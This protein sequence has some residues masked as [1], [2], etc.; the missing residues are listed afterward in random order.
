MQN[1][2][3]DEKQRV[4]VSQ[5]KATKKLTSSKQLQ[6]PFPEQTGFAKHRI[7]MYINFHIPYLIVR[8]PRLEERLR[9]Q[10]AIGKKKTENM[11]S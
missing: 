1:K 10:I 2:M 3:L 9:S 4:V 5:R 6:Q 7:Y 8:H 11:K